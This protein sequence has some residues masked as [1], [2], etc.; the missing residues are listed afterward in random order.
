MFTRSELEIKTI[1]E[2]GN[3][4]RRYGLKPI[5]RGSTKADYI[6]PVLAFPRMAIRQMVEGKGLR[7]PRW[8]LT[9]A[10]SEAIDQMGQPTSEQT[11]M[12]K[13]TLEGQRLSHPCRYDQEKLFALYRAKWMLEQAIDLLNV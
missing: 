1:E 2:L 13:A 12:L 10:I 9:Q 3:L 11:A 7:K 4:C 6:T 8:E 5:G